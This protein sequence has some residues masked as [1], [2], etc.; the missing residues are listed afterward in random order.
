MELA[1]R[2][3]DVVDRLWDV[4]GGKGFGVTCLDSYLLDPEI[5]HD[6]ANKQLSIEDELVGVIRAT[7]KAGMVMIVRKS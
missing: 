1:E 3:Q 7:F 2:L 5:Q 4:G 6:G